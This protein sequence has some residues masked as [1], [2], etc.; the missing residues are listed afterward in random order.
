M[1][2]LLIIKAGSTY[3]EI[4]RLHGDFEVWVRD[5]L[6]I[7]STAIQVVAVHLDQ[8]L[9]EADTCSGVVITGSH[10]MVSDREPW[11]ER[12]ADWLRDLIPRGIP[13]LGICYGHQ[14]LTH[15]LGG[16]VAHHGGGAEV[17]TVAIRLNRPGLADPLF[18]EFPPEFLAHA[19][20]WQTAVRLPPEATVL[21]G[22]AHEPHHIVRFGPAAWGVQ[23]HPEFSAAVMAAY[24]EREFAAGP[25]RDQ[26]LNAVR[27]TPDSARVLARFGALV[28]GWRDGS[29]TGPP[30]Q[31]TMTGR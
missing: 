27:E 31:V 14:L 3:P 30:D 1:K 15:A 20:H 6:R 23:F 26:L 4:A 9:P 21:A 17:G 19:S 28:P 11:S 10:A 16:E 7:A 8:P 2:P 22:S 29:L 24:V 12:T 5:G 18:G 13:V 25:R